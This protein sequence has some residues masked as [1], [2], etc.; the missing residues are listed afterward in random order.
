M[1]DDDFITEEKFKSVIQSFLKRIKKL[2][3]RVE[4][5]EEQLNKNAEDN[6]QSSASN[7]KFKFSKKDY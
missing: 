3:T 2:E 7:V 1:D 6:I 4:I 5:L